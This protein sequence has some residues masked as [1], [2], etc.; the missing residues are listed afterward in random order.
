MALTDWQAQLGAVVVGAGTDY[1]F[2]G[3]IT[4]LGVPSP[5][6]SDLDKGDAPGVFGGR[7]VK[8]K[9]TIGLSVTALGDDAAAVWDLVDTLCAAWEP[10]STDTTLDICLPGM[11]VVQWTGRPRGVDVDLQF[12]AEGTIRVR[13]TFD[14]LDPDGVPVGS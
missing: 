14:A 3:P 12:L 13:L 11:G 2:D 8:P 6:T 4:G 7:D 10:T 9:R 5:R 1:P